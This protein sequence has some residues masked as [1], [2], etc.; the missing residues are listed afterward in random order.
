[1]VMDPFLVLMEPMMFDDVLGEAL[2]HGSH[3]Y[4]LVEPFLF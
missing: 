4:V 3:D 2:A 1:M